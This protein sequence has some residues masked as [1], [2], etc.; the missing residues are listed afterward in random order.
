MGQD[1]VVALHLGARR[2]NRKPVLEV[3]DTAGRILAWGKLGVN[4]LT[5]QLVRGEAFALARLGS[6]PLSRLAVPQLLA[7][8]Q[9][10][11]H[12]LVLMTPL[13]PTR[14][15][16][17][18]DLLAGAASELA[19]SFEIETP[20]E[21]LTRYH[22]TLIR[23]VASL[24]ETTLT[25]RMTA[26]IPDLTS[27][28]GGCRL[29]AWHGDWTPWNM[30]VDGRRLCVWDWERLATPVPRGMDLLHHRFQ[31]DVV[32]RSRS[33]QAAALALLA[34]STPSPAGEVDPA[35]RR[36]SALAVA[37]LLGLG[38]RYLADDQAATGNRLGAVSTWL[39]P[40]LAT[41]TSGHR[42]P[43]PKERR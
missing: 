28:L 25:A 15:P 27:S 39:G 43:R 6:I 30:G 18:T 40:V 38:V 8:T 4:D 9:W 22:E 35:A 29:G 7:S 11:G 13:S 5:D 31:S 16:V 17:S 34:W 19:D 14:A 33:P 20:D 3:M 10:R 21:A 32:L 24:P 2:A 1:V 12:P 26:V 37:Y 42:T 23:Q 36:G 41:W